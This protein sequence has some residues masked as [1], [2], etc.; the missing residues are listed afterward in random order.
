VVGVLFQG[1]TNKQMVCFLYRGIKRYV[2]PVRITATSRGAVLYGFEYGSVAQRIYNV[3]EII[4]PA[5]VQDPNIPEARRYTPW[6]YE[7]MEAELTQEEKL[8]ALASRM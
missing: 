6:I 2:R 8:R 1:I 7:E 4:G 3:M 5:I